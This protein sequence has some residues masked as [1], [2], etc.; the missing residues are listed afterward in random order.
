VVDCLNPANEAEAEEEWE[1]PTYGSCNVAVLSIMRRSNSTVYIG[2]Y[3]C[4]AFRFQ[5]Y[6]ARIR[7]IESAF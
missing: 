2:K 7:F 5:W 3:L 4:Y 1:N 6:E